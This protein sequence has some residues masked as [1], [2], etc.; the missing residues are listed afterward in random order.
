[1][2]PLPLEG[3]K[4]CNEEHDEVLVE[5]VK[6]PSVPLIEII[7]EFGLA[8]VVGGHAGVLRH[9]A[10]GIAVE[11]YAQHAGHSLRMTID[12]ST[13]NFTGI[14]EGKVSTRALPEGNSLST[15]EFGVLV[16]EG[17]R[18]KEHV[19]GRTELRQHDNML[20]VFGSEPLLSA[21]IEEGSHAGETVNMEGHLIGGIPDKIRVDDGLSRGEVLTVCGV[22]ARQEVDGT[23]VARSSDRTGGMES[24]IAGLQNHVV[25]SPHDKGVHTNGHGLI[26]L[27]EQHRDECVQLGGSRERLLHLTLGDASVDLESGHFVEELGLGLGLVENIGIV[28]SAVLELPGLVLNS[29][30]H[31][32]GDLLDYRAVFPSIAENR[33]GRPLVRPIDENHLAD[34]IDEGFDVLVEGTGVEDGRANINDIGEVLVEKNRISDGL[35]G[36]IIYEL[37]NLRYFHFYNSFRS[38]ELIVLR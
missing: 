37:I 38:V 27:V 32:A 18:L 20:E 30:G 4:S 24:G 16:V 9:D 13:V 35:F 28:G 36:R 29:I 6:V 1:M 33:G 3:R 8:V 10:K 7:G 11:H 2:N 14:G 26:D 12:S 25:D 34:V 22:V 15:D 17:A 21:L 23:R 31:L 19:G 5:V